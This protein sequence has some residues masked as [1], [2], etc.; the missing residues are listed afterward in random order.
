LLVVLVVPL[1]GAAF[2]VGGRQAVEDMNSPTSML[3]F[4][5]PATIVQNL[6]FFAVPAA[7][8]VFR[9]GQRLRSIGLTPLPRG[10]D[11]AAGLTIG[12]IAFFGAHLIGLGIEGIAE[13]FRHMEWVKNALEFEKTNPVAQIIKTLPKLGIAGLVLSVLSIGIAAPLGEEMFFRG[14]A[15]NALKRRFGLAAGL[16]VSSLL[17]TLPHTYALGLLPVFLLGLLMAWIYHNSG[18]LW[19]PILVHAT[20]NTASVL[21]AFFVP[22]LT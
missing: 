9:Y 15:F 3:Y 20:N 14:F 17:F 21:V 4:G 16:I 2:L 19:I 13:Q 1:M 18:S 6:V 8:I 10:R 11:W 7:Y 12:A 5:L 22:S